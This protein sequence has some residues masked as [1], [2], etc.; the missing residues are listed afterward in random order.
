MLPWLRMWFVNSL[1]WQPGNL[2]GPCSRILLENSPK[3]STTAACRQP[4]QEA[5]VRISCSG[6]G[7]EKGGA[8][9]NSLLCTSVLLSVR[10]ERHGGNLDKQRQDLKCALHWLGVHRGS[11]P[12]FT[13]HAK[14]Q[15][16]TMPVVQGKRLT[17]RRTKAKKSCVA[18]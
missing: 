7:N 17:C 6:K 18:V 12:W 10:L 9:E 2:P 15:I 13:Q 11:S 8:L 4:A 16:N 5:G 14:K 1:S 3:Q